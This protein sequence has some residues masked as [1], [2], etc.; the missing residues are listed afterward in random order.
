MVFFLCHKRNGTEFHHLSDLC[1]AYNHTLAIMLHGDKSY[2]KATLT[3]GLLELQNRLIE[4][5][6]GNLTHELFSIICNTATI[7][8]YYKSTL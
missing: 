5:Y 7:E 2:L 1:V 6:T 4:L 3:R 8:N